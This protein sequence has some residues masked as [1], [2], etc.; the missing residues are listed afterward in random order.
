MGTRW[1]SGPS[2]TRF[3]KASAEQTPFEDEVAARRD[4][5]G[6]PSAQ[7]GGPLRRR[8]GSRRGLGWEAPVLGTSERGRS[9]ARL[10]VPLVLVARYTAVTGG[11]FCRDLQRFLLPRSLLDLPRS[12]LTSLHRYPE[13]SPGQDPKGT[14]AEGRQEPAE[15]SEDRGGPWDR[16]GAAPHRRRGG[17]GGQRRVPSPRRGRC[18][19]CLHTL[20]RSSWAPAERRRAL[21]RLLLPYNRL[22]ALR[23]RVRCV[24]YGRWT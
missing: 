23:A 4:T 6:D 9:A 1:N 7:P 3:Y 12:C 11:S 14:P 17:A 10:A 13:E 8:L 16:G 15:V 18:W 24:T 21:R 20:S 5:R 19:T 2:Q 22:P